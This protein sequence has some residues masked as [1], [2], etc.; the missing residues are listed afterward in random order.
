MALGGP[1]KCQGAGARGRAL[2]APGSL[3]GVEG[4]LG[5]EAARLVFEAAR[6]GVED[7]WLV[8]E[9]ARLSSSISASSFLLITQLPEGGFMSVVDVTIFGFS[10]VF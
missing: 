10:V 3:I 6:L 1:S 5:L 9:D 7:D 2:L 8:G 4:G